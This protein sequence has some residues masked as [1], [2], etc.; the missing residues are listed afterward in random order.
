M[1][2][3]KL[4]PWVVF[5]DIR[6]CLG[7]A[8]ASTG[9]QLPL[10]SLGVTVLGKECGRRNL[11]P[12]EVRVGWEQH[13]VQFELQKLWGWLWCWGQ[14]EVLVSNAG[15]A[16]LCLAVPGRA[17]SSQA[18]C[19]K[20]KDTAQRT[21]LLCLASPM[22]Q[23]STWKM[24]QVSEWSSACYCEGLIFPAGS[25]PILWLHDQQLALGMDQDCVAGGGEGEAAAKRPNATSV[26]WVKAAPEQQSKTSADF[27]LLKEK[28]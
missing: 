27:A 15:N 19:K 7:P 16:K 18:R 11:D 4:N 9:I 23:H 28:S 13:K 17:W 10:G 5:P 22:D 26:C 14:C 6:R 21:Q 8:Q 2:W 25:H 3:D 12:Q 24:D 20:W 1:F